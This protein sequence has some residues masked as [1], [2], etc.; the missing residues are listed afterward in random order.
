VLADFGL[1]VSVDMSKPVRTELPESDA[2]RRRPGE[3]RGE[4]ELQAVD[5]KYTDDSPLVLSNLSLHVKPGEYIGIVGPSGCGKSTLVRLFLGLLS[6]TNGKVFID[7]NDLSNVQLDEVRRSFGVVLQDYRLFPGSILENITA[8][9]DLEVDAVLQTLGTLGLASFVKGLPMGIHT[10]IGES[11]SL[12]SG[13]Q[14][15][16]MAMARALVG[17]PRLLIF[18]EATSALDTLCVQKVGDVLESLPITRIVFTHRLGTL[19]N[20]DRIVVLDRGAIA[21]E[22]RY[23]QLLTTPGPFRTMFHGKA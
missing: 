4:I 23:D 10:V 12:F 11:S 20:C 9:R 8:G 7:G 22:G 13:G 15:Q 5:F 14:A 21:Q 1:V 17:N 18:D 19:R 6:P 16:L 2:G 3:S